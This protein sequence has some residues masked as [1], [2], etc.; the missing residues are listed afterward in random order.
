MPSGL[1]RGWA[2][3]GQPFGLPQDEAGSRE[4]NATKQELRAVP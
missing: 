4:G 2:L 1:T 3:R